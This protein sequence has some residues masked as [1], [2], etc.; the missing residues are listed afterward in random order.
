[1]TDKKPLIVRDLET[2]EEID[3]VMASPHN[4]ERVMLGML[5]NM[6]DQYFIDDSAFDEPKEGK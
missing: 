3:R 2:R 4:Y 5:R 6:R 1:M